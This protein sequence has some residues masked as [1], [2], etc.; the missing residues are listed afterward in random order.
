MSFGRTARAEIDRRRAHDGGKGFSPA[1]R[2]IW[3]GVAQW[4]ENRDRGFICLPS[5]D[6]EPLVR[7]TA[8]TARAA[9]VHHMARPHDVAHGRRTQALVELARDISIAADVATQSRAFS[10]IYLDALHSLSVRRE[11][12]AAA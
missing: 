10:D 9:M 2:E 4:A 3:I 11:G 1:M 5:C 12:E 6:W 7:A 8:A